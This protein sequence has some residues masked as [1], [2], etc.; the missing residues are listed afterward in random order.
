MAYRKRIALAA[1]FAFGLA[2]GAFHGV[3]V[4]RAAA[5]SL[6]S[7]PDKKKGLGAFVD[8]V[9][10]LIRPPQHDQLCEE[11]IDDLLAD[12]DIRVYEPQAVAPV[13]KD[14]VAKREELGRCPAAILGAPEPPPSAQAADAPAGTVVEQYEIY[15]EQVKDTR[16]DVLTYLAMAQVPLADGAVGLHSIRSYAKTIDYANCRSGMVFQEIMSPRKPDISEDASVFLLRWKDFPVIVDALHQMRQSG[17]AATEAWT[18]LAQA[19]FPKEVPLRCV[20]SWR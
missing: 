7:N 9:K 16:L 12:R 5:A 11:F 3:L 10:G 8:A 4:A 15:G 20:V 14:V 13:L 2:G 18:F 17:S 6:L 19:Q 1:I